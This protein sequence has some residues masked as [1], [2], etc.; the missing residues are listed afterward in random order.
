MTD[1][2][3]TQQ[4][5]S[6]WVG[7]GEINNYYLPREAAERV[8]KAWKDWGYPEATIRQEAE[9]LDCPNHGGNYDCTPF[10]R[11]CEGE[12]EYTQTNEGN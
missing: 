3:Q 7:G 10:C 5:Y 12:Q 9:K 4:L 11:I 1:T 8:A 2:K 6:V